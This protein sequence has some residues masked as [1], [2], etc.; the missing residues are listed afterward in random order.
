MPYNFRPT[1]SAKTVGIDCPIVWQGMDDVFHLS[2]W[3]G[4]N[5]QR[6]KGKRGRRI[7]L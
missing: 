2:Q 1:V 5:Y 4:E 3:N 6:T 7:F